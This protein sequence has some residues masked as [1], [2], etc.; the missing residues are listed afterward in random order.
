MFMVFF[1]RA[2]GVGQA[3]A[4]HLDL[5]KLAGDLVALR[6]GAHVHD[7][8]LQLR[9]CTKRASMMREPRRIC[10]AAG[11]VSE[12]ARPIVACSPC[13]ACFRVGAR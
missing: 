12:L 10:C 8:R 11:S 13:D 2:R 3:R 7:Q 4:A 1:F 6:D 5:H 9:G